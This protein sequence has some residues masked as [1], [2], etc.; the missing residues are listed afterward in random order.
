MGKLYVLIALLGVLWSKKLTAQER[1]TLHSEDKSNLQF[2]IT[3]VKAG[4]TIYISG[5]S[6]LAPSEA[7]KLIYN[8]IEKALAHF[9]VSSSNV[10]KETILFNNLSYLNS[11]RDN[12][13]VRYDFYKGI[14]PPSC[15]MLES[16]SM[17]CYVEMP[18]TKPT[19]SEVKISRLQIELVVDASQ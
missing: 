19:T 2:L 11:F 7:T 10:V 6:G 4:Q 12:L 16:N 17:N 15:L 3:S 13:Q 1:F 9:G 8:G 18:D 14:W 5:S